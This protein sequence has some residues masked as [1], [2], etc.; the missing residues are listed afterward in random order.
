MEGCEERGASDPNTQISCDAA[1]LMSAG[2]GR[3]LTMTP[4][5]L[6]GLGLDSEKWAECG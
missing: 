6:L 5:V 2:G 4:V 1:C 3:G